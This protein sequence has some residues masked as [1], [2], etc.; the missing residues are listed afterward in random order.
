MGIFS[1][2]KKS[3]EI[4]DDSDFQLLL[5]NSGV[6][7]VHVEPKQVKR[8]EPKTTIAKSSDVDTQGAKVAMEEAMKLA[9]LTGKF[10]L[11]LALERQ[12]ADIFYE[13]CA[14]HI[15]LCSSVGNLVATGKG[16]EFTLDGNKYWHWIEQSKT[17]TNHA[18][19]LQD[20]LSLCFTSFGMNFSKQVDSGKFEIFAKMM[21]KLDA[22]IV[23][24]DR[25]P[26]AQ[27][28]PIVQK[29]E[30]KGKMIDADV[31][32]AGII[33]KAIES[34]ETA[35]HNFEGYISAETLAHLSSDNHYLK[36]I[37]GDDLDVFVKDL[38]KN[39]KALNAF[40]T[41]SA[42]VLINKFPDTVV[43]NAR[44]RLKSF[45]G[46][47]TISYIYGVLFAAS[48]KNNN[49]KLGER[50]CLVAMDRL[51]EIASSGSTNNVEASTAE[52][53]FSPFVR[54]MTT[55]LIA[56]TIAKVMRELSKDD[57]IYQHLSDPASLKEIGSQDDE[58][59]AVIGDLEVFSKDLRKSKQALHWFATG[60]GL[61]A[62]EL[63]DAV[64]D[65][66][67]KKELPPTDKLSV[68]GFLLGVV[69]AASI[70]KSKENLARLLISYVGKCTAQIASEGDSDEQIK[71][72][73]LDTLRKK[74]EEISGKPLPEDFDADGYAA[75]FPNFKEKY[76]THEEKVSQAQALF[77]FYDELYDDIIKS[78]KE[79]SGNHSAVEDCFKFY[80]YKQLIRVQLQSAALTQPAV[81]ETAF[82]LADEAGKPYLKKLMG[83]TSMKPLLAHAFATLFSATMRDEPAGS[84][85][86]K[87]NAT[88][89]SWIRDMDLAEDF[90]RTSGEHI[91]DSFLNAARFYQATFF[92]MAV[93]SGWLAGIIDNPE[94][95]IES[96]PEDF[97]DTWVSTNLQ[98]AIHSLKR[99][100]SA[101]ANLYHLPNQGLNLAL[102]VLLFMHQQNNDSEN[103][104]LTPR[105]DAKS[106]PRF[107][108]SLHAIVSQAGSYIFENLF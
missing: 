24:M 96:I 95:A 60:L 98:H 61:F 35:R 44:T 17:I 106:I 25:K 77:D 54:T 99:V 82:A 76:K 86:Q 40:V 65:D 89:P 29:E 91:I 72:Q 6:K 80:T 55:R 63:E 92:S 13:I 84:I 81:M 100:G 68:I 18:P 30:T 4:A 50:L 73:F 70:T 11:A 23:G 102:L 2:K 52:N 88:M 71:N 56:D 57:T 34:A 69:Q 27:S 42:L 90:T 48:E 93:T 39:K 41:G 62:L 64:I 49:L 5:K 10:V 58:I 108:K 107:D 85:A 32:I 79:E 7:G 16:E 83:F 22:S 38:H 75:F 8:E 3:S 87:F 46:V 66:Y 97:R 26:Q 101:N 78:A 33:E 36:G 15:N 31:A 19:V 59:K 94:K 20:I 53:N 45:N 74:A 43:E 47:E 14:L 9:K 28:T 12:E 21:M 51:P 67:V 103:G 104:N 37:I 1:N 105:Y